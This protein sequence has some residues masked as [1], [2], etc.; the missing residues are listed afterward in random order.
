MADEEIEY[1]E[2]EQAQ[3]ADLLN[4]LDQKPGGEG[5]A[6][7]LQQFNSDL[8][9]LR[10]PEEPDFSA[11]LPD[12]FTPDP[13]MPD[14]EQLPG[15][16]P[17]SVPGELTDELAPLDS[18]LDTS[19]DADLDAPLDP[20]PGGFDDSLVSDS[21]EDFEPALEPDPFGDL[22]GFEDTSGLPASTPGDI[23]DG[24]PTDPG[25][26]DDL[27]T[28]PSDSDDPGF[29][30]DST[31]AEGDDGLGLDDLANLDLIGETD[32]SAPD[33][34]DEDVG[35]PAGLLDPGGDTLG[36]EVQIGTDFD[37]DDL[38]ISDPDPDT[39]PDVPGTE[40]PPGGEFD[41]LDGLDP[42]GLDSTLTGEATAGDDV[43]GE[44]PAGGETEFDSLDGL[45]LGGETEATDLDFT[46]LGDDLDETASTEAGGMDFDSDFGGGDDLGGDDLGLTDMDGLDTGDATPGVD[47]TPLETGG[48]DAGGLDTGGLDMGS[49]LDTSDLEDMTREAQ[50]ATG[51]GDEFTDEDLANIRAS[52]TDYPPGIKK[53]VIDAIVNDKVSQPDQRLLMNMLIEQAEEEQIADFLEARLG[54]RPDIAPS[55]VTKDGVQIIY[56]EGMSPEDQAKKRRRMKLIAAAALGLLGIGIGI[57]SGIWWNKQRSIAGQYERGLQE[58]SRAQKETGEMGKACDGR[59]EQYFNRALQAAGGVYDVEFLNRYGI[60]YLKAGCY[61]LAH[62]KLFGRV[63]FPYGKDQ[64]GADHPL[65]AWN[66]QG[67]RA[68]I[69]RLKSGA[70]WPGPRKQKDGRYIPEGFEAQLMDQDNL[71]RRVEIAGAYIVDRLRNKELN[72][73]TL[74]NLARFH[75]HTSRNFIE[76]AGV[77]KNDGLAIDYYRLVLTL[78]GETDDIDAL[79][80][81]GQI[82]YNRKEFAAAAR[83][84]DK[85]IEQHPA[86]IKGHAGLLNTYIEMW[87]Q[88]KDDPRLVIL[89]HRLIYK[90]GLESELPIYIMTKLAGFYIELDQDDLLIKYQVDP[91]DRVSGLGVKEYAYHMLELIFNTEQKRDEEVIAGD[92][93]GEGFY[94]RGRYQLMR[95]EATS[96]LKQFQNAHQYDKRHFLAVNAMG[97]YYKKQLDFPRARQYFSRAIEVYNRY[98]K[99]YGS[100]PEDETLM[101]GDIG[102]IYFNLASLT[103]LRNAGLPAGQTEGYPDTRIYPD[104]ALG[105]ETPQMQNRRKQLGEAGRILREALEKGLKE[106]KARIQALYWLGWI[107]YI[108]NN[109]EDALLNWERLNSVYNY[110]YSD[111]TLLM[112]RGNAYFYKNQMRSALGNFRKV[113]EDYERKAL[114]VRNPNASDSKHQELYLTLSAVYNNLG[115]IYEIEYLEQ[116][117]QGAGQTTLESL[118]D[119]ALVFYWKAVEAARK[120][121]RDNEIAR[122]NV[123]LAFRRNPGAN[124]AGDSG[125]PTNRPLLDDWV[126]PLL[127]SLD[128]DLQLPGS[129]TAVLNQ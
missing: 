110:K 75:S 45:G 26:F 98:H 122:V 62:E 48:L 128:K 90:Q 2:D 117:R 20:S 114:R 28:P 125:R 66:R 5:Y 119:K 78:M 106:Q 104:R 7:M 11:D 71:P 115:A 38:S 100:R 35:T 25:G 111:P 82:Y 57:I 80:G 13:M 73:T 69:L 121:D 72:R 85:I 14:T 50:M 27:L 47:A 116:A 83:Q 53:T 107:D 109:F 64:N 95:K 101:R 15:L 19:L 118:R 37:L 96:A 103:F 120:I 6:P 29:P 22:P 56:A 68:P 31:P 24:V 94:Q 127:Y 23:T 126:S 39:T 34:F 86:M 59:A 99:D 43:L 36:E 102:K 112:G 44:L 93:Y 76:K 88:K 77:Y 17:Q 74:I 61:R 52:L 89:R 40:E 65:T 30:L 4:P 21:G 41:I 54:Y 79:A 105:D 8:E 16:D 123:K 1:S 55:Q 70:S 60:A 124:P 87:K 58:L 92:Q 18:G 3:I 129:N 10:P 97:E 9:E 63:R 12:A 81:I 46:D 108:N 42:S 32:T 113:Q 49:M 84:Y 91:I 67:R 51:I 33:A